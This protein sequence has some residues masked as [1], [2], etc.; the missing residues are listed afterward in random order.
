MV[1]VGDTVKYTNTLRTRY[2]PLTS[3]V[4]TDTFTDIGGNSMTY[5]DT[6]LDFADLGSSEG[7][8]AQ[9]K[10]YYNATFL[11]D[12]SSTDAGGL[13][14]QVSVTATSTEALFLTPLMME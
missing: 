6:D 11:V 8:I 9:E 2:V 4:I 14:N 5:H 13:H 10:A 7:S 1:W 12:Q 3:I